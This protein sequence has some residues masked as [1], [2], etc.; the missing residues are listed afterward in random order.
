MTP[1]LTQIRAALQ[2]LAAKKGRP[3]YELCTAKEVKYAMDNGIEHHL[4]AELPFFE[5]TKEIDKPLRD[6]VPRQYP[7]KEQ[8]IA[9]GHRIDLETLR[10]CDTSPNCKKFDERVK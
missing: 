7:S 2:N 3:D 8:E 6:V 5:I 9:A 10:D 1:T 4:I